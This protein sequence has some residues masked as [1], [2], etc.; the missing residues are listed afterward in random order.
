MKNVKMTFI[1]KP[2]NH[3]VATY[4]VSS[5]RSKR[6]K[7]KRTCGNALNGAYYAEGGQALL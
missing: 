3:Q 2:R 4:L 7:L 1:Y 6:C 5:C